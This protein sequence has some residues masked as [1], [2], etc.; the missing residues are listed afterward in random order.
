MVIQTGAVVNS[1][2][3]WNQWAQRQQC[4]GMESVMQICQEH[5]YS[6]AIRLRRTH[7]AGDLFFVSVCWNWRRCH[8]ESSAC[9]VSWFWRLGISHAP[10]RMVLEIKRHSYTVFTDFG[11]S[12]IK[13]WP[14]LC[15]ILHLTKS[16]KKTGPERRCRI[17]LYDSRD[18]RDRRWKV[19][20]PKCRSTRSNGMM[21]DVPGLPKM[22]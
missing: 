15:R 8:E 20:F 17:A 14:L 4:I 3:G 9:N 21:E 6:S 18:K 22:V 13:I 16:W 5:F 12:F 7:I 11:W 1:E 10:E 2:S 19:Y